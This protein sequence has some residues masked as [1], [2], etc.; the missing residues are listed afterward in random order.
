MNRPDERSQTAGASRPVS[1]ARLLCFLVPP[2]AAL[3]AGFNGI[4]QVLVPGQIAEMDPANK[5]TTLAILTTFAAITSM[6]GIPLGG[7]LSD[8]TRSR[9]GKRTP[10]IVGLSIVSAV[11]MLAMGLSANL[12]MFGVAYS[13]LWLTAN[14]NQGALAAILP[15]RVPESRRGVASAI[16]GLG[17]PIGALIG[18]NIASH[19]G[20]LSS[21]IFLAIGL[22]VTCVALVF[23]ARETSSLTTLMPVEVTKETRSGFSGFFEAFRE[24]DFTFAFISRF[25]LFMAYFTVSGYLF[26][27]LSDYIGIENVPDRNVPVAVSTLV[28]ISV[29]VW[30]VIATFCG[31]LADKLDRRKL[32]VGISAVGLAAT[33][34]VPIVSPTWMGMVVYSVLSGA[35]IGT[36]FAVDLA[37]M[38]LVLPR[39]DTAG[40]DLGILTVA[41][42]LPQIMSS[43]VAGGLITY[44]G[45]YP[46]LY[47]FGGFCAL[48]AGVVIFMIKKVR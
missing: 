2:T 28:T 17:P 10:W 45:G 35:F 32:F 27:T 29:G 37:V 34:I 48:V 38:S 4:Q 15:D 8:R 9:F 31:W 33:M 36:Y 21:Y 43:V 40:R 11:L 22:V 30:V 23:G 24:R 1:L 13:L 5:V 42:G 44:V 20:A 46:A 18:V 19:V 16:L 14:M 3:M 39:K 26:Y 7:S 25:M 6:V 47:L 12:V 41:T